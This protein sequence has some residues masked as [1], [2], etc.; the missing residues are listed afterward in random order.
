MALA[1]DYQVLIN[2]IQFRDFAD[3][4][5]LDAE[6]GEHSSTIAG[7]NDNRLVVGNNAHKISVITIRASIGGDIDR[8]MYERKGKGLR[9]KVFDVVYKKFIDPMDGTPSRAETI[10]NK[11]MA[12]KTDKTGTFNNSAGVATVVNIYTLEG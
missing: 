12:L 10:I 2:G 6:N 3:E 7:E 4:N 11:K 8:Y 5:F 9:D 1:Y